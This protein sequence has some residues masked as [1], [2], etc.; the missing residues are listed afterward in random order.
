MMIVLRESACAGACARILIDIFCQLLG[1]NKMTEPTRRVRN[2]R[3]LKV[4]IK[5]SRWQ[6]AETRLTVTVYSQAKQKPGNRPISNTLS[7]LY[8]AIQIN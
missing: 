4:H 6:A 5:V 1:H 8:S 3:E 7:L 2:S